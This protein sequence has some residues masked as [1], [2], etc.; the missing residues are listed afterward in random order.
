M[1]GLGL[2]LILSLFIAGCGLFNLSP[3]TVST[4]F[5]AG[6][7]PAAPAGHLMPDEA[8]GQTAQAVSRAA[9]G[10]A[11]TLK[12]T[13]PFEKMTGLESALA[14]EQGSNAVKLV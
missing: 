11:A 4:T 10:T 1:I 12:L 7:S 3:S 9:L 13:P 8:A 6:C 5:E 2:L 14:K